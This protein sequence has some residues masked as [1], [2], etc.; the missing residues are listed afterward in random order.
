MILNLGLSLHRVTFDLWK[1]GI[2]ARI[3]STDAFVLF[4]QGTLGASKISQC[5]AINPNFYIHVPERNR[6]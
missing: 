4:T 1:E 2:D 5:S 3:L 6:R